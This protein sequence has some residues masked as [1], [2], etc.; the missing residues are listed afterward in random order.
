M[1]L[2][3]KIK[4][5][6]ENNC[7]SRL[8]LAKRLDTNYHLIINWENDI[9]QPKADMIIKL[10]KLFNVS[11]GYLLGIQ[12]EAEDKLIFTYRYVDDKGK[13]EMEGVAM[14]EWLRCQQEG[15]I[16]YK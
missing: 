10:S 16:P 13:A 4:E 1:T 7:M 3:E 6:R 11:A 9:S 2:G 5:I 15:L 8:I 12:S 14:D